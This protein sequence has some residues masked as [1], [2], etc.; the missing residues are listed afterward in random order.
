MSKKNGLPKGFVEYDSGGKRIQYRK[1]I[2]GKRYTHSC[3]YDPRIDMRA[4]FEEITRWE[5]SIL[6]PEKQSGLFVPEAFRRHI[7]LNK[8]FGE[9]LSEYIDHYMSTDHQQRIIK[10][11]DETLRRSHDYCKLINKYPLGNM[12]MYEVTEKDIQDFIDFL[13]KDAMYNKGGSSYTYSKTTLDKIYTLIKYFCDTMGWR[14]ILF[15]KVKKAVKR[16]KLNV[17]TITAKKPADRFLTE[18]ETYSLFKHMYEDRYKSGRPVVKPVYADALSVMYDLA[19]RPGEIRGLQKKHYNKVKGSLLIEQAV[20]R[21]S[22]RKVKETK[23]G[24]TDEL[25]LQ[26]ATNKIVMEYVG[27]CSSPNEFIFKDPNANGANVPL[28]YEGIYRAIK[29]GMEIAGIDKNVYPYMA[30]HSQISQIYHH[31]KDIT[32][33][34]VAARHATLRTT[35]GYYLHPEDDVD[36]AMIAA[37]GK[38]PE[39]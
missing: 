23:T 27:K 16:D 4:S 28:S 7:D 30:R 14:D 12:R 32:L 3:K 31:S 18:Q 2:N 22:K 25:M 35:V 10:P 36:Q 38:L 33:A 1:T 6:H 5:E 8:T 15:S 11:A 34:Q 20:P 9:N 13:A 26:E 29:K 21:G 19:L 17:R 39:K 37:R 24:R